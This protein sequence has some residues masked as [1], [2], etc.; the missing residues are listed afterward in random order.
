MAAPEKVHNLKHRIIL[1]KNCLLTNPIYYLSQVPV[2][3][4]GSVH[5]SVLESGELRCCDVVGEWGRGGTTCLLP[6][7]AGSATPRTWNI[8]FFFLLWIETLLSYGT[9]NVCV[10]MSQVDTTLVVKV[11]SLIRLVLIV[12]HLGPGA[13]EVL[14]FVSPNHLRSRRCKFNFLFV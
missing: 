6:T 1:T 13:S 14:A 5:G 3:W 8:T 11:G 4:C 12:L 9:C 7:L 10:S 2:W